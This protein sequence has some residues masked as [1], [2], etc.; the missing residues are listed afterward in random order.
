MAKSFSAKQEDSL[1]RP[2]WKQMVRCEWWKLINLRVSFKDSIWRLSSQRQSF[3][4][5]Q[6]KKRARTE[7]WGGGWAGCGELWRQDWAEELPRAGNS[8]NDQ[9]PSPGAFE[10][11]RLQH[12]GESFPSKA[13][14]DLI[15]APSLDFNTYEQKSFLITAMQNK[16]HKKYVLLLSF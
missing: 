13:Q 5:G 12:C 10:H 11:F 3:A 2:I 14:G 16:L 8:L 4:V 6:S 9:P 1:A 7:L 15:P